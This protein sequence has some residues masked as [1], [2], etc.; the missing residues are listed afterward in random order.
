MTSVRVAL[1]DDHAIV[2]AG[3]RS[4]LERMAGVEVAGEASTGPQAL[5]VAA[6]DAPDVILMD[7]AMPGL[8]GLDATARIVKEHPRVRVIILS[9]YSSEEYVFQALRSGAAGYLVKDSVPAE[10]EVAIQAVCRG[11]SYLSP[12]ISRKVV[13]DYLKRAEESKGPFD[14]LTP[15]QRQILQLMAEGKSTKEIAFT[16]QVSAKTVEAHRAQIMERLQIFD[17]PGLVRYAIR[18]G[19]V[20]AEG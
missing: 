6:R 18:I 8:N 17:V 9:M 4:L 19:L 13:N 3:I 15:R 16:L 11:E 14:P 12:R 10:L 20:S 7:I 5:E 2:R 1:A